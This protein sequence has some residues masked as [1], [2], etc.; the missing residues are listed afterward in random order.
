MATSQDTEL[1]TLDTRLARA[2]ALAL[3]Q[4]AIAELQSTTGL[5]LYELGRRLTA[6]DSADDRVVGDT[7]SRHVN[8]CALGQRVLGNRVL[9]RAAEICPQVAALMSHPLR[10]VAR[11]LDDFPQLDERRFEDFFGP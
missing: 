6:G 11:M 1:R 2:V 8:K 7:R 4:A 10:A 9:A 5:T 3:S